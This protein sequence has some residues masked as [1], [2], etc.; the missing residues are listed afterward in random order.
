[1]C[2]TTS[3][4]IRNT[5]YSFTII[6]LPPK[7]DYTTFYNELYVDTP[8]SNNSHIFILG[9]FNYHFESNIFPIPLSKI[10]LTLSIHQF[11]TFPTH[12]ASH[13]TIN[14]L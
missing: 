9:D 7:Q 10:L 5:V 6:Y 1:M 3:L 11:L 4:T 13:H 8:P 2:P 14:V 12:I